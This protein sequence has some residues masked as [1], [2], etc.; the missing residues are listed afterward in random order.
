VYEAGKDGVF[1]S[2]FLGKVFEQ[3]EAEVTEGEAAGLAGTERS[4]D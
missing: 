3:E 1:E 4:V 2:N